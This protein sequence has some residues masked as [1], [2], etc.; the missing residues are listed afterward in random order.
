MGSGSSKDPTSS[1]DSLDEAGDCGGQLYVS[2]KME[3]FKIRG[4]LI[5]HVFGSVPIIGSW[6]PSRALPMARE[7]ASMWELS[8]VVPPNH[9]TR[10]FLVSVW[11]TV[12]G[13]GFHLNFCCRAVAL[14]VPLERNE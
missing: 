4:E 3:N 8:F 13:S 9:G 11:V 7:S 6:D 5:P 14:P 12:L 2:L 1:H 10:I